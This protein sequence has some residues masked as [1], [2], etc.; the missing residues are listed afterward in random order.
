MPSFRVVTPIGRVP[1]NNPYNNPTTPSLEEVFWQRERGT[2]GSEETWSDLGVSAHTCTDRSCSSCI[3]PAEDRL[4]RV[5]G[6][7]IG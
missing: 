1:Y 6:M 3:Y 4:S 5:K 7:Q 2:L